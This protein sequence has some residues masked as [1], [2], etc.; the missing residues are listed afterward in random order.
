MRLTAVLL[1]LVQGHAVSE[2]YTRMT[3]GL[4]RLAARVGVQANADAGN[5]SASVCITHL[6]F[7]LLAFLPAV[8]SISNVIECVSTCSLQETRPHTAWH[9]Q[10]VNISVLP[11]F[12]TWSA[13]CASVSADNLR[14]FVCAA[15]TAWNSLPD[16]L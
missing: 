15:A 13:R 12:Q 16:S 9:H 4:A 6:L 2:R 3:A 7:V 5:L 8:T 11:F 14:S 1:L 10:G